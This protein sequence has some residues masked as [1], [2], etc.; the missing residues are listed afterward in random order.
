[1]SDT[2]LPPI[3]LTP[4]TAA[5]PAELPCELPP[6]PVTDKPS[7]SELQANWHVYKA[8]LDAERKAM[9]EGPVEGDVAATLLQAATGGKVIG[10]VTWPPI[11][12]AFILLLPMLHKASQGHEMLSSDAGTVFVMA[13]ALQHPVKAFELLQTGS[14]EERQMHL[15]REVFAFGAGFDLDELKQLNGWITAELGRLN[16][17]AEAK[18]VGKA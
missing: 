9:E 6:A 13:Y 14:A 3:S 5:A 10:N 11:H 12:G 8:G 4:R 16:A 7:I 15:A 18:E 17:E 2:P 1:M